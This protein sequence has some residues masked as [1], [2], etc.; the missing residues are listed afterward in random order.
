MLENWCRHE[1]M[2]AQAN[3]HRMWHIEELGKSGQENN[4]CVCKGRVGD[5]VDLPPSSPP[6]S[7]SFPLCLP[8]SLSFLDKVLLCN[9]YYPG[10]QRIPPAL[11]SCVLGLQ[12]HPTMTRI[13]DP[14]SPTPSP[15]LR[16][17]ALLSPEQTINNK[18]HT[19]I[20]TFISPQSDHVSF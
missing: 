10:T 8:P 9:L 6:S 11:V 4:I 20:R 3:Q 15:F 17:K 1:V 2:M 5:F 7:H 18:I 14:S 13:W 12:T 19:K 16:Y